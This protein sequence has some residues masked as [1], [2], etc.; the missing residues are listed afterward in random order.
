MS[1]YIGKHSIQSSYKSPH[2]YAYASAVSRSKWELLYYSTGI[3]FSLE[4]KGVNNSTNESKRQK[5]RISQY[6]SEWFLNTLRMYIC[7]IHSFLPYG[8]GHLFIKKIPL[9]SICVFFREFFGFILGDRCHLLFSEVYQEIP[10][11]LRYKDWHMH[12]AKGNSLWVQWMSDCLP[13]K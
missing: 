2:K 12:N 1:D 11:H 3:S 5:V 6:W 13:V 7:D 8:L 9:S 4:V 10:I